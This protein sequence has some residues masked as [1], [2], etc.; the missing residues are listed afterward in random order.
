M[1]AL[2]GTEEKM[3]KKII[4]FP[5]WL[6]HRIIVWGRNYLF[7]KGFIRIDKVESKVVS[8]GNISFGGTG[9]T[10]LVIHLARILT[11]QDYKV[12]ILLRGY[13]GTASTRDPFIVSDGRTIFSPVKECGDEAIVIAESVKV[14]VIIGK[15]RIL[16]ARLAME[17][18]KS[19]FILLD[20][21]FQHRGIHRDVDIVLIT[22]LDNMELFPCGNLR[23]PLSSLR[24]AS[25]VCVTKGNLEDINTE[26][27]K[28]ID[29]LDTY[30]IDY[31]ISSWKSGNRI[32]GAEEIYGEKVIIASGIGKFDFFIA[33]VAAMGAIVLQCISYPDHYAFTEKDISKLQQIAQKKGAGRI[34]I[35]E[36][37]EVKLRAIKHLDER[38]WIA[39]LS[40]A[41]EREGDFLNNIRKT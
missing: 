26:V 4:L 32:L 7:D 24:R 29:T 15:K 9:K 16:S 5:F 11:E 38:Y 35:T 10:P 21:G 3:I 8:I 17:K 25:M 18:F 39:V 33:Q 34:V 31:Y 37:D 40:V 30:Q 23:E 28:N 2:K 12:A 36:K 19:D 41:I 6:L 20:D 13:R 1:S 22:P 14:P 27:K